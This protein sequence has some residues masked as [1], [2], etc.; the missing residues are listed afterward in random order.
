MLSSTTST[1][2]FSISK[3]L[4]TSLFAFKECIYFIDGKN[5]HVIRLA[6]APD[7]V[8]DSLTTMFR[9]RRDNVNQTVENYAVSPEACLY[10]KNSVDN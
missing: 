9:P 1:D 5:E 8:P 2:I 7:I 10:F 3:K 6:L 4:N